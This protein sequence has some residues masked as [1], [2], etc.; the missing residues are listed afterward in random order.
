MAAKI[1][2]RW[3]V[4]AKQPSAGGGS[5]VPEGTYAKLKPWMALASFARPVATLVALLVLGVS[6][7]APGETFNEASSR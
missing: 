3:Y 1:C 2:Q 5:I 4:T 7:P 6:Q